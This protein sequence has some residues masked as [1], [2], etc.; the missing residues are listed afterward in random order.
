MPTRINH[1]RRLLIISCSARKLRTEGQVCAWTLYDGV[2]YRMLKRMQREETFPQDV[3]IVILSARYG[4][5]G[6]DTPIAFYDQLMDRAMALEQADHN[7]SLLQS[8]LAARSYHAVFVAMGRTYMT[9]I[10]PISEW[11]PENVSFEVAQGGI[12]YKLHALKNWL[13]ATD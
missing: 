6:T 11:L 5:I 8:I 7:R 13:A 3:D 10:E 9:A 2:A 4:L 12:G 1:S